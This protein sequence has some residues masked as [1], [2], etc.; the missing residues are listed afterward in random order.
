MEVHSSYAQSVWMVGSTQNKAIM[1][2]WKTVMLRPNEDQ[3]YNYVITIFLR[4][5]TNHYRHFL[6]HVMQH[7]LCKL[8]SHFN[9][10]YNNVTILISQNTLLYIYLC[11]V[12]KSYK[13]VTG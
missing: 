13:T 11:A 9:F 6:T 8:K 10:C 12:Q 1:R 5:N 4:L 3:N 7:I 2:C